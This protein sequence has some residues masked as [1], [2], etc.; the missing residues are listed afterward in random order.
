MDLTRPSRMDDPEYIVRLVGHV[1]CVSLETV[2]IVN[3]L[4][5]VYGG[6]T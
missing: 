2:R 1:V 5:A 3:A 6:R 4:P